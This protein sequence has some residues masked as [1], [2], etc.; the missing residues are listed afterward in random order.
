MGVRVNATEEFLL[1]Q[2]RQYRARFFLGVGRAKGLRCG[3][4]HSLPL[5]PLALILEAEGMLAQDVPT[6]HGGLA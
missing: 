5:F 6:D 4:E 3:D 1:D 2:A